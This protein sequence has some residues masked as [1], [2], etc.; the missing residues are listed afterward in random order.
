MRSR[1]RCR[2]VA[3]D[4]HTRDCEIND[5]TRAQF[6]GVLCRKHYA[7]VPRDLVIPLMAEAMTAQHRIA[8][9]WHKRQ[10]AY[11]RRALKAEAA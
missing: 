3:R 4:P 9:K 6:K 7:M 2:N 10:L 11:V 5:C 1:R 8:Q